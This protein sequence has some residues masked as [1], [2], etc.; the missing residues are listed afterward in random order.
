MA[1]SPVT[2]NN[3]LVTYKIKIDG[4]EI[5]EKYPI[6]D[7][8]VEK[9]INRLATARIVI[10]MSYGA[11]DDKTFAVSEEGRFIPGKSLEILLGY[12]A[13]EDTVFKG[14]IVNIGITASGKFNQLIIDGIDKAVNLTQGRKSKYFKEKTDKAIIAAIINN[15]G[16][17]ASVDGTEY[18]H[19]QL[20]Q[21]HATDWDFIRMR[22]EAN[23]LFIYTEDGM[24]N[25]K[26]PAVDGTAK[27][28]VTYGKDI[29]SI[30]SR[31]E[32]GYQMPTI[33]AYSW[34]MTDQK[35]VNSN[36]KEPKVNSHGNLT[37]KALNKASSIK[38]IAYYNSTPLE[39]NDMKAWV[40]SHLLHTRLARIRGDMEII[41]TP[42]A[43]LN[44]IISIKGFGS[45]INGDALI[46]KVHHQIQEGVWITNI[47]FGLSPELI[48]NKSEIHEPPAQGLLPAIHGLQIAKV[49]KISDDPNNE[50]RIQVDLPAIPGGEGV[51][52]RLANF[53]STSGKG[54]FFIPEVDDEVVVGFLNNDPR[55]AIIL[56]S[57]YSSKIK[58][59]YPMDKKNPIKAIITKNDLKL[60]FDDKEKIIT[61]E[62]PGGNKAILSDKDKS[63]EL[64]DESGNKI[65]M[66]K[67]GITLTSPKEIK[68]EAGSK[69]ILSAKSGISGSASRGN[70][71]FEGNNVNLAG[72]MGFE[73]KAKNSTLKGSLKATL[74][75]GTLCEV[76]GTLVKIN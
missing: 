66:K 19:K 35:M 75:G 10:T 26:K 50:F 20:I 13:K 42:L 36:A 72:K 62:T 34:S 32:S 38:E 14:I 60:E 63:I 15:S 45:R 61:I 68:F 40:N 3:D 21:Y 7:L 29:I 27:L 33:K 5:G 28:E 69:I 25:V 71:E 31:V 12:H 4:K 17:T 57:M 2:G 22:A 53:Y 43:K 49:M 11:G 30:N 52:A 64:E 73:A 76:K 54:V 70:I 74:D 18:E 9:V 44:T 6:F 16:A 23:G 46:T 41:G 1:K 65:E 24:V 67:S 8:Q 56:G 58:T 51:W 59:P 47:G 37:G 48:A 55:F 39:R